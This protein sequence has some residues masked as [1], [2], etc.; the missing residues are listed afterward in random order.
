MQIP[1]GLET[2]P[3]LIGE[4]SSAVVLR[5]RVTCDRTAGAPKGPGG[6]PGRSVLAGDV[7]K[8]PSHE[9]RVVDDRIPRN[10][11]V[12]ENGNLKDVGS[13]HVERREEPPDP[14]RVRA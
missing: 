4:C 12:V 8:R 6:L 2:P 7:R 5:P 10:D 11:Y 9:H 3:G 1:N 14:G 13:A